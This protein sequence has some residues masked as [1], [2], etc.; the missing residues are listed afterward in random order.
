MLQIPLPAENKIILGVCFNL[1]S[2]SVELLGLILT[3]ANWLLYLEFD[4]KTFKAHEIFDGLQ[5]V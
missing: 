1:Y 2:S 4:K 5:K 3:I